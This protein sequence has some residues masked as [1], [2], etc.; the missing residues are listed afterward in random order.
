MAIILC[1]SD[2]EK[3]KKITTI[4]LIDRIDEKIDEFKKEVNKIARIQAKKSWIKRTRRRK[5]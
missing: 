1:N 4:S 3:E 2:L 5:R